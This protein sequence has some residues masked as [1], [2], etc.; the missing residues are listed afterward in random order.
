MAAYLMPIIPGTYYDPMRDPDRREF[1]DREPMRRRAIR[2]VIR[3]EVCEQLND[4]THGRAHSLAFKVP[5][6]VCEALLPE[7]DVRHAA[8]GRQNPINPR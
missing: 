4:V 5:C 1:N 7:A 8:E 6:R 3:C 2:L